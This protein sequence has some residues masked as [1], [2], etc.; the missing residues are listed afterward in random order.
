MLTA[1]TYRIAQVYG[2]LRRPP[3]F[4]LTPSQ[5]SRGAGTEQCDTAVFDA[6]SNRVHQDL[7]SIP[8]LDQHN[9]QPPRTMRA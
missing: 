5:Q 4:S 2:R 8:V 7:K 3:P 9:V 1:R 6:D